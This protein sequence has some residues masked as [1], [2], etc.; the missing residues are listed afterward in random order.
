MIGEFASLE[1]IWLGDDRKMNDF[2]SLP[3]S[4]G[5][6]S[7]LKELIIKNSNFSNFPKSFTNLK[8]LEILEIG[9]ANL[10]EIPKTFGDFKKLMTVRLY[11]N[12][13]T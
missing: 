5:N 2:I 9:N 7:Q 6:L 11:D 8:N 12:K 3:E 10:S 1:S 4:I 13:L